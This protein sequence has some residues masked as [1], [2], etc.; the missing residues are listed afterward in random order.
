MIVALI[1]PAPVSSFNSPKRRAAWCVA[2]DKHPS[3]AAVHP[4]IGA[5]GFYAVR[6]HPA[7]ITLVAFGY[8][9]RSP[10][11][12]VVSAIVRVCAA[13]TTNGSIKV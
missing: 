6:A 9:G 13:S 3:A 5:V 8:L 7:T 1:E 10:R 2:H 12:P 4:G 11:T